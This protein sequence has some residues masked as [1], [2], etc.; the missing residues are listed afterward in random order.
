MRITTE[1]LNI[2]REFWKEDTLAVAHDTQLEPRY[3][4]LPI[5]YLGSRMLF[6]NRHYISR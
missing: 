5:G 3:D 6:D 2:P 1:L 4:F